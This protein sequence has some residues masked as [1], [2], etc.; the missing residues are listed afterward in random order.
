MR[1]ST[2]AFLVLG[3]SA[4]VSYCQAQGSTP[5]LSPFRLEKG[6]NSD[7]RELQVLGVDTTEWFAFKNNFDQQYCIEVRNANA[8]N[9]QTVW[10]YPCNGSTAQAWFVDSLGRIRSKLGNYCLE[11]GSGEKLQ[12]NLFIWQCHNEMWQRYTFPGGR[13]LNREHNLYIGVKDSDGTI[14]ED[15]LGFEA[16]SSSTQQQW[17]YPTPSPSTA[18]TSQPTAEPTSA[19]TTEVSNRGA[20]ECMNWL[21]LYIIS[22]ESEVILIHIHWSLLL[23]IKYL[24]SVWKC[25]L[26]LSCLWP[27]AI[28]PIYDEANKQSNAFAFHCS[29]KSADG[30][31]NIRPHYRGK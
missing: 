4:R 8:V 26:L 14:Q 27:T 23:L 2:R 17:T 24:T 16:F 31:A 20:K 1:F 29:H 18:P 19:P 13:I 15:Y 21:G 5:Q 30:R 7:N 11:G 9:G 6:I 10:L 25:Y 22:F 3:V 12:A 28:I